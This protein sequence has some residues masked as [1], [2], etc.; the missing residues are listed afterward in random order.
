VLLLTTEGTVRDF[1]PSVINVDKLLVRHFR[2]P[3]GG[4]ASLVETV[5][6]KRAKPLFKSQTGSIGVVLA[7]SHSTQTQQRS[8][9]L[10][11]KQNTL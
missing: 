3:S 9:K 10:L 11:G 2:R 4:S 7:R 1:V 5:E 8:L 6:N